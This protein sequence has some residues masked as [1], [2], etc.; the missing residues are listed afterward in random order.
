[1]RA[2]VFMLA[3]AYMAMVLTNWTL[4]DGPNPWQI[5]RGSFSS[6]VRIASQW[7]CGAFYTWTLCAPLVLRTRVFE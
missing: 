3:S 7:L 5:D 2:Q 6:W 4:A 1:M